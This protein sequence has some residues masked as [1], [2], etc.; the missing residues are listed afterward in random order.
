MLA[1]FKDQKGIKRIIVDLLNNI[2]GDWTKI[3]F[4]G[5]FVSSSI[6]VFTYMLSHPDIVI[7]KTDKHGNYLYDEKGNQLFWRRTDIPD[8]L[9]NVY[10]KLSEMVDYFSKINAK[11][12]TV[13]NKTNNLYTYKPTDLPFGGSYKINKKTKKKANKKNLKTLKRKVKKSKRSKTKK[14]H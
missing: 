10:T 5:T 8:D 13:T 7:P 14:M 1:F 11:T 9:K 4:F 6:A 3:P 2:F 12:E